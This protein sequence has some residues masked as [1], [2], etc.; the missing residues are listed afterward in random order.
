M[1]SLCRIDVKND[2]VR[3]LLR[4]DAWM[5]RAEIPCRGIKIYYSTVKTERREELGPGRS[6]RESPRDCAPLT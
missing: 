5:M 1:T 6:S 3:E 4:D 2:V